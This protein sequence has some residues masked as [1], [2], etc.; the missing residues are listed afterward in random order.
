MKILYDGVYNCKPTS[1][2]HRYFHNI[3]TNMPGDFLKYSS[4]TVSRTDIPNHFIP[5]FNH[6]RPHRLSFLLEYAWF[7]R[8]CLQS[9]DLIH[10][11]YYNLSNACLDLLSKGI[12]HIITVHDMIH[13]LFGELDKN[14]KNQRKKIL[15]NSKAIIAVSNNTKSDLLNLYPELNE[16]KVFVVH[17]SLSNDSIT[18]NSQ[19]SQDTNEKFLLYVG[20]REGYKNFQILLPTLKNLNQTYN[21]QLFVVGPNPSNA[22]KKVINEFNI[23]SKIRFLGNVSDDYL[24]SLYS[25]CLAFVYPSLYEGFGYPLLESMSK[26]AIPIASRSSSIPEVLG[27][28]GIIVKPNCSDSITA[29]V[30]KINQ[31]MNYENYMRKQSI[32]RSNEF[33]IDKNINDTKIVY[34]KCLFTKF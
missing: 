12:P 30:L 23:N 27:Y 9:I 13:E 28:A 29:A 25:G 2:S 33:N 24:E 3:I 20:H 1:G 8:Q 21:M 16:K 7:K 4:T 31:D 18:K 26:G 11:A 10:S 19:S 6:F 15:R 14:E 22:E 34:E 5:P 17:H 32:K